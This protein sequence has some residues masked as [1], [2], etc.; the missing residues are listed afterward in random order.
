[1]TRIDA[2]ID[3]ICSKLGSYGEVFFVFDVV[4][5]VVDSAKVFLDLDWVLESDY[6]VTW[7][8]GFW[9]LKARN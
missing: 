7:A 4:V 1:M 2:V 3:K 8:V 6:D 9:R 5:F